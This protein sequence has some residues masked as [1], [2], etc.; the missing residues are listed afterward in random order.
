VILELRA[1]SE[2]KVNSGYVA[3]QPLSGSLVPWRV[4]NVTLHCTGTAQQK[5]RHGEHRLRPTFALGQSH[6]FDRAPITST[7]W[8]VWDRHAR[9]PARLKGGRPAIALT[10][11][12]ARE[13]R[14]ELNKIHIANG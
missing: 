8:M 6:Q 13:I 1:A 10:E 12:Q 4:S 2:S 11:E 9:A 7:G 5:N 3:G 14:D